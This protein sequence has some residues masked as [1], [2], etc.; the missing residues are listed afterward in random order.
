MTKEQIER[1]RTI[2]LAMNTRIGGGEWDG[3][4]RYFNNGEI[5]RFTNY[6]PTFSNAKYEINNDPNWYVWFSQ[7]NMYFLD[8]NLDDQEHFGIVRYL[9]DQMWEI[10]RLSPG[11][12]FNIVSGRKFRVEIDGA[13]FGAVNG[14]SKIWDKLPDRYISAARKYVVDCIESENYSNIRDLIKG[15]NTK[16]YDF[17]EVP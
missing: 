17:I 15:A 8:E 10:P 11:E 3:E 6:M 1:A 9:N 5:V 13:T 12:F 16:C 7:L 4:K 2:A 14:E